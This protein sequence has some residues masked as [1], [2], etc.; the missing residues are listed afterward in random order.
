MAKTYILIGLMG[1]GKSTTGNCILAR[2]GEIERI[3]SPFETSDSA[4]GCTKKF[5]YSGND[6]VKILD[7]VGFG[8]PGMEDEKTLS[9]LKNG[10]KN[11]ENKVDG[12]LFIV[13]NGRFTNEHVEFFR[14][15]QEGVFL[16]KCKNN[17]ILVVTNCENGWI[18]KEKIRT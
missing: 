18:E 7:T 3:K 6:N 10:L 5:Q 11:I 2:S 15:I 14:D 12:V 16:N 4:D 13:R 1:S 9:E 8:D 17:S